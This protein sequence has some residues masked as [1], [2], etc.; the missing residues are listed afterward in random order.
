MTR[1]TTASVAAARIAAVGLAVVPLASCGSKAQVNRRGR[2]AARG[3][4]V[5]VARTK[6][7][8][9]LVDGRGHTLYL[10]LVDRAGRSA[11]FGG[12]ARVWPPLTVDGDPRA[13]AGVN[14]SKLTTTLRGDHTRQLVYNGHPLYRM[15]ADVRP[16]QTVGQGF[17]DQWFVVSPAGKLIGRR[18]RGGTG[19]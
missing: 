8:R 19:Y 9:I 13:G 6:L 7:G 15:S 12:C 17:L 11:C 16:G 5:S 14:A 18:R 1:L 2:E 4:D 3:V 10:F